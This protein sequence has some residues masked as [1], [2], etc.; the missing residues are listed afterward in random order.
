[1]NRLRSVFVFLVVVTVVCGNFLVI[2]SLGGG[3]SAEKVIKL[4]QPRL[5]GSVALE[6]ALG[7]QFDCGGN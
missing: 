3:M 7:F 4:P 1:M 2:Y 6:D 5:K